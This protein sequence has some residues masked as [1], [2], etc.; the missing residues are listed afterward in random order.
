MPMNKKLQ[1]LQAKK[2]AFDEKQKIK[3]ATQGNIP[4]QEYNTVNQPEVDLPIYSEPIYDNLDEAIGGVGNGYVDKVT[5]NIKDNKDSV[6]DVY[7]NRG[8]VISEKETTSVD[9]MLTEGEKD[10]ILDEK[11]NVEKQT[12]TSSSLSKKTS[13]VKKSAPKTAQQSIPYD[14][15]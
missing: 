6:Q 1:K 9:R 11:P 10:Y 15:V 13:A 2:D 7:K 5:F 3:E 12:K 4:T 8:A 14:Y